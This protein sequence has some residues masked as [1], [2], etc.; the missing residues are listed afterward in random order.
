[1]K[2]KYFQDGE[3]YIAVTDQCPK[4]FK[5]ILFIG[6]SGTDPLK[7]E[8]G[9]FAPDSVLKLPEITKANMPAVWVL[10]FGYEKPVAPKKP[11]P[12]EEIV[13]EPLFD[14]DSFDL[15][16]HIPVRRHRRPAVQLKSNRKIW[17]MG[18]IIGL[19]IGIICM[20][21]GVI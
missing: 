2:V 8:E 1:M 10:A 7:V 5:G 9:V 12:V 16:T 4:D 11:A 3:R 15:I 14:P 20:L 6:K 21:L 13:E 19:L 17:D 18:L